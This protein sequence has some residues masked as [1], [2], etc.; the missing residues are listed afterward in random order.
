MTGFKTISLPRAA[1][2][3]T[4]TWLCL[5]PRCQAHSISLSKGWLK[6]QCLEGGLGERHTLSCCMWWGL[7]GQERSKAAMETLT[8][9]VSAAQ[10]APEI[11]EVLLVTQ[12]CCKS[13]V[14]S[15]HSGA[16]CCHPKARHCRSTREKCL[17]STPRSI[18]S[19]TQGKDL[20]CL[21]PPFTAVPYGDEILAVQ[22]HYLMGCL[23]W[24]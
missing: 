7:L 13:F 17:C 12:L 4:P 19:R 15:G 20:D 21:N 14:N 6:S 22:P 18:P 9:F 10:L 8:V 24:A 3:F 2:Q 1:M 11:R 23:V 16:S 5:P